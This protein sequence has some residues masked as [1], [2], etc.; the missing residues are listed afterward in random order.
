M[1]STQKRTSSSGSG[2]S[3]GSGGGKRTSSQSGSGSGGRSTSRRDQPQSKPFR[4]E[5]GALVCL[6]LAF[7]GA[8]GYFKTEDGAFI[9]L[10]CNLLK[11][12]CGYGFYIAPPMLLFSAAILLFHRGRPVRLR[13]TGALLL[14]VLLGAILHLFL[15]NG[16]YEWSAALWGRL[17]TD[18]MGTASGGVVSGTLAMALQFAFTLVGAAAVLLLLSVAAV[19][20]ALRMTPGDVMDYL[21]ER[22]E[23]R[24]EYDPDDYWSERS[25]KQADASRR[26]PETSKR[27]SAAIDIPVDDGPVLAKKPTNPVTTVRRKSLFD[28]VAG[29]PVPGR[30][31][32][33][34]VLEEDEPEYED[35]PELT[36]MRGPMGTRRLEPAAAE[37]DAVPKP[38]AAP[39]NSAPAVQETELRPAVSPAAQEPVPPPVIRE[40]APVKLS[41]EEERARVQEEMAREIE[42]GMEQEAGSYRYPPLSLL[43]EGG[44]GNAAA[45]DDELQTNQQR[46]QDALQSFGVSAHIVNVVRGPSITR[47]ELELDRGS[48]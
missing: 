2:R 1:A 27:R 29:V 16:A 30:K 9:A 11:G 10:F 25:G 35:V 13:L 3:K 17:W 19:L 5:L 39:L 18:G 26:M 43:N 21:R 42:A 24:P 47:Y 37:N 8:I 38:S 12:L 22:R 48:S 45:A 28:K 23:M 4:R 6:L 20:C 7:F 32:S 31:E 14:P 15:R 46:L 36:P 33:G 44:G 34:P 41:K 40:P